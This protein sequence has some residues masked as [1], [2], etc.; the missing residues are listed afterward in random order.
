MIYKDLKELSQAISKSQEIK[1]KVSSRGRFM[2][3]DIGTKRIGVAISDAGR[4]IANPKLIIN[5]QSNRQ[6]FLLIQDLMAKNQVIALIIGLPINMD[7]SENEMTIFV[8][9]FTDNLNNF[10]KEVKILFSEERLTSFAARQI[11]LSDLNKKS[12]SKKY[13]D[14]I[15]ASLILQDVLDSLEIEKL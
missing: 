13:Y 4:L 3:L 12:S 2:A 1:G 6:D 15:A 14:D 7:E 5:R 11:G 8:K 10:L 9:K